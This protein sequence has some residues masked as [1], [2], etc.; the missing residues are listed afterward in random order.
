MPPE[1]ALSVPPNWSNDYNPLVRVQ[2]MT[3]FCLQKKRI[4]IRI[5]L[6]YPCFISY[7][8]KC[9]DMN[10][11]GEWALKEHRGLFEGTNLLHGTESFLRSRWS[12]SYSGISP[13]FTEPESS[14][15]VLTRALHLFWAWSI[16][17]IQPHQISLRTIL[18][19]SSHLRL[20]LHSGLCPPGFTTKILLP[21]PCIWR[22]FFFN[23]SSAPIQCPGLLFS[24]VIFVHGW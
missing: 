10:T 5:I 8:L 14:F 15:T 18:M 12:L 20:G 24:S 19:L 2:A 21:H 17:S 22:Y 13:H 11:N 7:Q 16:Q 6:P 9:E 1:V 4:I 3:Q 23:G